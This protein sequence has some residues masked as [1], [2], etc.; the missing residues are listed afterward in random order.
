MLRCGALGLVGVSNRSTF[1]LLWFRVVQHSRRGASP[2]GTG[3]GPLAAYFFG[4][5]DRH[6]EF[7]VFGGVVAAVGLHGVLPLQN[8][9][10]YGEEWWTSPIEEGRT[11]TC[12][13]G[14]D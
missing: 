3:R 12:D 11:F 8:K 7:R 1:R 14:M 2:L 6:M 4:R 9:S 5:S 10:V 13:A